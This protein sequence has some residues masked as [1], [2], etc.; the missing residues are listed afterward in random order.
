[1]DQ[2]RPDKAKRQENTE[3]SSLIGIWLA[4]CCEAAM[5]LARTLGGLKFAVLQHISLPLQ[6]TSTA[7]RPLALSFFR[8]FA[9]GTYLDKD[10]VTARVL[11]VVTNFEKVD[12]V[13][14]WQFVFLYT[15]PV[16]SDYELLK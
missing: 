3:E 11:N 10:D 6:T 16:Q 1:M 9:S 14:V 12:P 5:S 8:Q 4:Y 2:P 7:A 13:K 15:S